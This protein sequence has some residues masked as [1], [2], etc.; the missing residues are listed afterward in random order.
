MVF[1]ST[2]H[3]VYPASHFETANGIHYILKGKCILMKV[4]VTSL[5]KKTTDSLQSESIKTQHFSMVHCFKI[6]G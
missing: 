2:N 6:R 1:T 4:T 5:K 3:C